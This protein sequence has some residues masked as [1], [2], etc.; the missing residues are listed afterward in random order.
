MIIVEGPDG[1][2]KTTLARQISQR[3]GW[4]L[5]ESP[6]RVPADALDR[7]ARYEAELDDAPVVSD[8][9]RLV[10]ELVYGLVLR[11]R[12]YALDDLPRKLGALVRSR[13]ILI[14]CDPGSLWTVEGAQTKEQMG[15]VTENLH[16]LIIAYRQLFRFIREARDSIP[17][18]TIRAPV[19]VYNRK[20]NAHE[21]DDLVSQATSSERWAE[22]VECHEGRARRFLETWGQPS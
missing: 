7:L 17:W 21:L 18:N 12:R 3:L 19:L 4:P 15:G 1:S 16:S 2:G 8:R 14:L 10:S 22:H 5:I 9:S 20:T 6:G 13:A 11:Q